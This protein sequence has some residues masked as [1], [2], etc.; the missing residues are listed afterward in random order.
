MAKQ[1]QKIAKEQSLSFK[2]KRLLETVSPRVIWPDW[3][4]SD[5]KKAYALRRIE[6]N[7]VK[8]QLKAIFSHKVLTSRDRTDIGRLSREM[9]ALVETDP[10]AIF[11]KN[12]NGTWKYSREAAWKTASDPFQSHHIRGLDKYFE[13]MRGLDDLELIDLHEAAAE[14][15]HYFGNHPKN[16][17]DIHRSLHVGR[18][19]QATPGYES[20]HGW[21]NYTDLTD[22]EFGEIIER[23]VA[24]DR[25]MAGDLS[26]FLDE[27]DIIDYNTVEDIANMSEDIGAPRDPNVA[28]RRQVV[29]DD[30][31]WEFGVGENERFTLFNMADNDVN[32]G[33]EITKKQVKPVLYTEKKRSQTGIQ[34]EFLR[35][36]PNPELWPDNVKAAFEAQD[37]KTL[38]KYMLNKGTRIRNMLGSNNMQMFSKVGGRLNQTNLASMAVA[39][40]AAGNYGGA[41]VNTGMLGGTLAIDST[42]VQ[43][44]L[45]KGA[46]ALTA[47]FGKR[48][49]AK[50]LP[51]L[52]IILSGQDVYS[53]A[54]RGRWGASARALAGGV[55]GW[56]PGK[57]DAFAAT[58]DLINTGED[59]MLGD[60][61]QVELDEDIDLEQPKTRIRNYIGTD[62][63]DTR[64]IKTLF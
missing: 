16:R 28:L 37:A 21:L 57:G 35:Q 6:I 34:E 46:T 14:R 13:P 60:F 17:I 11:T 43:K 12:K 18:T 4:S 29:P 15:G 53:Y 31:Y 22:D 26:D 40:A 42:A 54:M 32:L 61:S 44:R 47:R 50:L 62:G 24:S 1:T 27:S 38:K 51:G 55:V 7:R 39:N 49:A 52:D 3:V 9:K 30:G 63:I 5:T 23:I 59:I 41:L 20:I 56:I 19:R 64:S 2:Q 25:A 36:N 45:A 48:S 58:M 10:T 33:K 8:K